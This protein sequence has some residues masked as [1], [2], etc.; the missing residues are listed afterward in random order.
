MHFL[1]TVP[2]EGKRIFLKLN[3]KSS[4]GIFMHSL[5]WTTH[6]DHILCHFLFMDVQYVCDDANCLNANNIHVNAHKLYRSSISFN[7]A[8]KN[9][10][11]WLIS[12]EIPGFSMIT[13][14]KHCC[15]PVLGWVKGIKSISYQFPY[16]FTLIPPEFWGR[17]PQV[18]SA[19]SS[20]PSRSG[21]QGLIRTTPLRLTGI[22]SQSI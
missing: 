17:H 6:T 11:N 10:L 5:R 15:R 9:Q 22:L 8:R 18:S 13:E 4:K 14:V 1:P 19:T 2:K 21:P 12:L 20:T 3:H 7:F 16:F